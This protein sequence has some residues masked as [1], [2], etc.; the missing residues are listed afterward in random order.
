[1]ANVAAWSEQGLCNEIKLSF[2]D[3]RFKCMLGMVAM[4]QANMARNTEI[5]VGASSAG[6][7]V[8]L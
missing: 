5:V 7:K 8:L 6:Y 2:L 4:F 1:V 3:S